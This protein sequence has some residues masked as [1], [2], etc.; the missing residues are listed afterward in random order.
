MPPTFSSLCCTVLFFSFLLNLD[1]FTF[2][3][4]FPNHTS[5]N[6][7]LISST[8]PIFY[9]FTI[10]KR[11]PPFV[12][13]LWNKHLTHTTKPGEQFPKVQDINPIQKFVK[14]IAWLCCRYYR[15]NHRACL[16]IDHHAP[17]I[18]PF[19]DPWIPLFHFSLFPMG[20]LISPNVSLSTLS[21]FFFL[22]TIRPLIFFIFFTKPH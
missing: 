6:Y 1:L 13:L 11:R 18:Y 9:Y 3:W 20:H 22:R 10:A 17:P 12:H 4:V 19:G 21:R 16:P 15:N 8:L 14:K 7:A 2:K 5:S